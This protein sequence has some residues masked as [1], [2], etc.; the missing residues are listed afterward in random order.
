MNSLNPLTL[1]EALENVEFFE[2]DRTDAFVVEVATVL[3]KSSV[4]LRKA[5]RV[6][7]WISV[8]HSHVAVWH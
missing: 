7:G 5:E 2:R 8:D 4:S 1:E 6:L 3:Y